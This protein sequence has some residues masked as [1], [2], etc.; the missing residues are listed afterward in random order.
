MDLLTPHALTFRYKTHEG[1]RNPTQYSMRV[2]AFHQPSEAE[3]IVL[4]NCLDS[5]HKPPDSGERRC[6][7]RTKTRR[8]D[9]AL[10]TGGY[11]REVEGTAVL[12]KRHAASERERKGNS[13]KRFKDFY[14]QAKARIWP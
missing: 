1:T 7:S 13:S 10:R 14:L 8:F 9:A 6:T 5:Y 12:Q 4:V 2:Q 11:M 3:Q